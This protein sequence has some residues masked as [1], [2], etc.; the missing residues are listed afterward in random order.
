[1]THLSISKISRKL[2]IPRQTLKED[3][4][5]GRLHPDEEGCIDCDEV[6]Q[7]YPDLFDRIENA[8]L[9]YYDAIK[10]TAGNWK[11]S[12]RQTAEK[13]DKRVLVNK[14]RRLEAECYALQKRVI[15]LESKLVER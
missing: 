11:D 4:R 15:E 2:G 9:D 8:K 12:A 7:F 1:M 14:I 6:R 5:A 10:A 13:E 3:V